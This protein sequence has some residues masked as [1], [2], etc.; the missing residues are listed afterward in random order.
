MW[1]LKEE[2]KGCIISL[3]NDISEQ[4]FLEEVDLPLTDV[5]EYKTFFIDS[6]PMQCRQ[7]KVPYSLQQ[8]VDRQVKQMFYKGI[9]QSIKSP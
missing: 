6:I 8:E 4:F 3:I 1:G 2:E 5:I 7:Y 9:I